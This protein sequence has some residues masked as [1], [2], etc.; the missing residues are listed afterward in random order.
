MLASTTVAGGRLI[1]MRGVKYKINYL[2]EIK[3]HIKK[4]K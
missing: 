1:S 4:I 3:K 2:Q